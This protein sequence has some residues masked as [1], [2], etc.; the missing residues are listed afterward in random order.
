MKVQQQRG[1][2]MKNKKMWIFFTFALLLMIT[3][4]VQFFQLNAYKKQAVTKE[5]CTEL[6]RY[7]PSLTMEALSEK[8]EREDRFAV[9]FG[10]SECPDCI[11]FEDTLLEIVKGSDF[12]EEF[13]FVNLYWLRKEKPED[14]AAWKKKLG[15]EQIPNFYLF[16]QGKAVSRVEWTE[17]GLPKSKALEWLKENNVLEYSDQ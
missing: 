15:F 3:I 5:G 14:Y 13:Y 1:L 10:S 6:Y 7:L 17:S 9:Y 8:I 11:H 2:H 16:E 4:T 12:H